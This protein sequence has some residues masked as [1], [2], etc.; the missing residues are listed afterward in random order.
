MCFSA[1]Q[2]RTDSPKPMCSKECQAR[3]LFLKHPTN[4]NCILL[5]L[6]FVFMPEHDLAFVEAQLRNAAAVIKLTL[7]ANLMS[8]K[9]SLCCFQRGSFHAELRAKPVKSIMP[10]NASNSENAAR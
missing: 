9:T 7:S 1:E 4:L 5:L 6:S 10:T 2:A 8:C 3:R